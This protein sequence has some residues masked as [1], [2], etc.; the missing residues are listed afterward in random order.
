MKAHQRTEGKNDEWLT[1]RWILGKLGSFDLDPCASVIRPWN[2]AAVHYTIENDGFNKPWQGRV[3]LNPPFNRYQRP[4]WMKRMAD[5]GNGIMLIPAATETDAWK[6]YVDPYMDGEHGAALF[7]SKR[8][9]FCDTQGV[10]AKANSGCSIALIAYG[11][12][13][14][15]ALFNSGL[16]SMY[17]RIK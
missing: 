2:T 1:P 14:V 17:A 16:G 9:H 5:H 10:E 4:A 11:K 8:P 3:W 12:E 7:L 13:N 15:Q 6:Q